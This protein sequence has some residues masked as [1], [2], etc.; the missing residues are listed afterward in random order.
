[1]ALT[2]HNNRS[3]SGSLIAGQVPG[4][5]DGTVVQIVHQSADTNG[6]SVS[7]TSSNFSTA[8]QASITPTSASN[9][10]L[11]IVSCSIADTRSGDQLAVGHRMVRQIASGGDTEITSPKTAYSNTEYI[12]LHLRYIN[13]PAAAK[14]VQEHSFNV[15]D[16]PNTT[17]VCNYKIQHKAGTTCTTGGAYFTLMEIKA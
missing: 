7:T 12:S 3:L 8:F 1:M 6:N 15:L 2:K 16:S 13:S 4:L 10:I 17:S 14:M 5:P 11:C 9:K